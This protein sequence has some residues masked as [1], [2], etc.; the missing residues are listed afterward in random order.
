V[1]FDWDDIKAAANIRNHE[2]VTFEEAETVFA[3]LLAR[4]FD[5]TSIRLRK[6]GTRFS[7]I[8]IRT[9]C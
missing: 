2:G 4:I 8:Q 3:D 5:D 6:N 9:G 1:H 7:A